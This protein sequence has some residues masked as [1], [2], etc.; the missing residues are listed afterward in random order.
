MKHENW[1][2]FHLLVHIEIRRYST[3]APGGTVLDTVWATGLVEVRMSEQ[4][5]PTDGIESIIG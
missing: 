5:R 4:R 2:T 1:W 3:T